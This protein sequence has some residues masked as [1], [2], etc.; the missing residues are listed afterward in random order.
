MRFS[1]GNDCRIRHASRPRLT[2]VFTLTL[3][4]EINE[5]LVLH[6]R[7]AQ[8]AAK[9]VIVEGALLV[10]GEVEIVTGSQLAAAEIL[11]RRAVPTVGSTLGHDVDHCAA[12]AAVLCFIIGKHTKFGNRIDRENRR[13]ISENSSFV[14][15]RIISIAVVHVRAIQE[16]VIG[17]PPRA[18]HRESSVGARRVGNL[19]RRAGNPRIE[20]DQLLVITAVHRKTFDGFGSESPAQFRR[21]GIHLRQKVACDFHL[22]GD[23]PRPQSSVHATLGRDVHGHASSNESLKALLSHRQVIRSD[24]QFRDRITAIPASLGRTLQA[25]ASVLRRDFGSRNYCARGVRDRSEN[26]STES[27]G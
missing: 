12:V 5:R 17:A 21:G 20:I 9:L 13:G 22:S 10:R 8:R 23:L 27:L 18:V 7:A 11:D 16:E 14:D 24:R 6:Q 19:V 2:T 4:V 15:G 26:G 1:G 3:I 25:R